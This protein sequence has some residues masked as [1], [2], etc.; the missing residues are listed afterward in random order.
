[1]KYS[2]AG[3]FTQPLPRPPSHYLWAALLVRIYE[4]FPLIST[5]CGGPMRIQ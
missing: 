4:V 1:V 3:C 2:E 5:H